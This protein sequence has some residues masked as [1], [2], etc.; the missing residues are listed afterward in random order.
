MGKG[1]ILAMS[2]QAYRRSPAGFDRPRERVTMLI[3]LGA[4]A[5]GVVIGLS[6]GGSVTRLADVQF[7]WWPLAIGGLALQLI[8]VPSMQGQ[9]DHWLALGLLVASYVALL[10]F[11]GVNLRLAGFALVGLGFAL[12]LLVISLNGGM[13]VNAH[14]LKEA[15]GP[16][17][18]VAVSRLVRNGG[19]KHHL[20][21]PN[22]VFEQLS[23]VIP[24]GRP[25]RNVFSVGDV[26]AMAG[27]AWVL[28]GATR[29]PVGRHRAQAE[30]GMPVLRRGGGRHAMRVPSAELRSSVAS[31]LRPN[32]AAEARPGS[33]GE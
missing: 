22:D 1:T 21:R 24:V 8:P 4:I 3:I 10:L 23:D 28:A 16:G 29:G 27:I 26:V 11:V 31:D 17:Y 6:L 2:A 9:A 33:L 25:V 18:S 15:S 20:G 13:P 7:R 5:L 32:A 19:A 30:L 14:A 12:N